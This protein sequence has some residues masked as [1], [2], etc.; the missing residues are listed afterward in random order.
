[1][2]A[3]GSLVTLE[4]TNHSD[5]SVV[6]ETSDATAAQTVTFHLTNGLS[7]AALNLWQTTQTNQ[8]IQHRPVTP[9]GGTFTCTFQP[10]SIY[11]LTTTTGQMKG[12]AVPPPAN[13]FSAAVQR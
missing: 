8:F 1:M 12:D 7:T 5:Y 4:S 3:G 2:P 6:V 13:A 10:A 9:V 11:T